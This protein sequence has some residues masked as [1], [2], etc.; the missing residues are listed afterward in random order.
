MN[1]CV[2]TGGAGFI[3]S[4]LAGALLDRGFNVTVVD[5][6]STG[7]YANLD[8]F[9]GNKN[10]TTVEVDFADV[11]AYREKLE[12]AHYLFHLAGPV[13]VKKIVSESTSA[14]EHIEKH[15]EAV[16][17][18]LYATGENLRTAFLA[19]SSE[20]YGKAEDGKPAN[21]LWKALDEATQPDIGPR[22]H[23]RWW[24]AH[25]KMA[26]EQ[27]FRHF[28][29]DTGHRICIGRMFNVTGKNQSS[30]SGMVIPNFI[31]TAL[32]GD[33]LPV[34]GDG[35]Q[36]RSFCSVNDCVHALIH[37]VCEIDVAETPEQIFNIGRRQP[38]T[39]KS[40]AEKVNEKTGNAG[41]ITYRSYEEVFDSPEVDDIKY[42]VPDVKRLIKYGYKPQTTLDE[43]LDEMIGFQK[44]EV[45]N[46]SH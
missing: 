18:L 39:I 16:N 35:S 2:I 4:N 36:I 29:S 10:L 30:T 11:E 23:P 3:G 41:G 33:P 46:G 22:E 44:G 1:N 17:N 42:R 37:L 40:L 15:T 14:L 28:A 38:I 21:E 27:A 5:D 24:Y 31:S 43:I 26:A 8:K 12:S 13:G 19:S 34:Y 7:D 20:I 6:F 9:A 45:T 25:L 32:E